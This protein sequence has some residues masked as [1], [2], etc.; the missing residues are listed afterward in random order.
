[1][2]VLAEVLRLVD[3]LE[4]PVDLGVRKA[5]AMV[6]EGEDDHFEYGEV[7]DEI[8]LLLGTEVLEDAT[9]TCMPLDASFNDSCDDL[10]LSWRGHGR[11]FVN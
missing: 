8:E 4:S 5:K 6:T 10:V 9:E 3:Q 1:M 11:T 7:P 2:P